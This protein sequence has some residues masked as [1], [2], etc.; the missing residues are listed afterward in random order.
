MVRAGTT[1]QRVGP[2]SA[3]LAPTHARPIPWV[4]AR[5][6]LAGPTLPIG[7]TPS[8]ENGSHERRFPPAGTYRRN[9]S[10]RWRGSAGFMNHPSNVSGVVRGVDPMAMTAGA[11]RAVAR[12]NSASLLP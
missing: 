6:A 4:G 12:I 10:A 9:A 3:S 2:A 7:P 8:H 11:G 5:E 1:A